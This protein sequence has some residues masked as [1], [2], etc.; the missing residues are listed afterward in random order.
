[1]IKNSSA[2]IQG[3]GKGETKFKEEVKGETKFK[4]V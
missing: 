1:M 3:R 4:L 2:K